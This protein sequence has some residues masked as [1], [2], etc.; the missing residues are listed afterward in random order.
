MIAP[1]EAMA[2]AQDFLAGSYPG[3]NLVVFAAEDMGPAYVCHFNTR[4]YLETNDPAYAMGPGP[5]PIG[6]P[7]DGSAAWGM[8]SA[9]S[10][11][12]QIARRYGGEV[13]SRRWPGRAWWRARGR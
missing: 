8:G 5:G 6:V 11:A 2:I 9:P 12:E 3:E 10:F 13:S 4:T 1:E 7:K